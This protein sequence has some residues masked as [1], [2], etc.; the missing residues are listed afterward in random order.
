MLTKEQIEEIKNNLLEEKQRLEEKI[1]KL[2]QPE[3]GMVNPQ[4]DEMANDAEE[5][6]YEEG[7]LHFFEKV[8]EKVDRALARIEEGTY[9]KCIHCGSDID[10]RV[11]LEVNWA[12]HC[13]VCSKKENHD[14]DN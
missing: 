10:D 2:Q 1:D 5:D 11:L 3:E 8:L 7:M 6:I 13:S 9:G 14:E 4:F 12:E